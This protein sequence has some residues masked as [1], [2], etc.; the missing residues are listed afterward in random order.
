MVSVQR[1]GSRPYRELVLSVVESLGL[2]ARFR[3]AKKILIKPNLVTAKTS[4]EGVTVD[5]NIIRHLV[6][7][8]NETSEAEVVVGESAL[9]D[10]EDVF[11]KLDVYALEESGCRVEDLEKGEWEQVR[12]PNSQ[13]FRKML[14]PKTA[15]ES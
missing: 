10:T 14:V 15:N 6:E 1:K 3:G 8:I 4:S 13:L 11:R 5:L 9:I 7:V 2:R 12:P